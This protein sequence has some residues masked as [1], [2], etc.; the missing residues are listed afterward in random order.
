M[1]NDDRAIDLLI[2][3]GTLWA[4]GTLLDETAVAIADGRIVALGG[5][6]LRNEYRAAQS[7]DAAGGL[8]TPSFADAHIHALFGG[9]EMNRCDLTGC[10]DADEV[11]ETI[12]EYARTHPDEEWILGGGWRMP[13]YEGGTPLAS[14]LDK[15]V[16]DRPVF[17]LNT[18]HHGAWV[19]S[20][21]LELAGITRDT[22]DPDDGVIERDAEGNPSGTLH[23]GA[24]E[25]VGALLPE[26]TVEEARTGLLTAQKR[27]F[28]LGITAWQEAILGEYGG[29]PD[30]TGV[31]R[32]LL[33]EGELK[34]DVSGALWTSR[35]FDGLPIRAFVDTLVNKRATFQ[36]DDFNLGT[37]KIMVDG[38][39]ENQTA[40]LLEPYLDECGCTK[41]LGL[42]YFTADELLELVPLLNANG[43]NVHMHAIGDR[44]VQY[45]LDAIAAVPADV[46]RARRNH[47]AHLQIVHPNDVPRFS[48]LGVAANMQALWAHRDEQMEDLTVPILGEERTD[49]HYPFGSILRS[50]ATLVCGSD[51]PVST[52]DPW[53]AIHVAVNRRGPG[54]PEAEPLVPRE[55][56]TLSEAIDAYTSRTHD[57]LGTGAGT[58][59]VGAK[60]DL[61][62]ADRNPFAG[63][64][65]D[66]YTTRNLATV[67]RGEVL[68]RS[69]SGASA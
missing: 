15:I 23:E 48:S 56:I 55:A 20:K 64:E 52:P 8:V 13:F 3:S 16:S 6:E 2:H 61:A 57:L 9:I 35:D 69:D 5:D 51:W 37:V 11:A 27:L 24:A 59:E 49:W 39:A 54:D 14:E 44:A 62:V 4:N 58:L 12:A 25:L 36:G 22:P 65:S 41:N 7:I 31:Y 68:F 50:G 66:I 18:D 45:A 46:R 21:A 17:L 67:W 28:S 43:F 60:A 47:I 63:P 32:S 30:L 33:D 10:N 42:A 34:G 1:T 19:N 53:Q 26:T 29:Y 38:V 40:A